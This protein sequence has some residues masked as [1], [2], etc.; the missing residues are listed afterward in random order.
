LDI[1]SLDIHKNR[2][3]RRFFFLNFAALLIILP[4]NAYHEIKRKSGKVLE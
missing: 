1:F 2:Q 3:I 4:F